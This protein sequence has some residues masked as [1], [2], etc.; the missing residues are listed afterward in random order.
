M[1][2]LIM[3]VTAGYGHN[4]TAKAM[5]DELVRRG[6]HVEILDVFAYLGK[7]AYNL[8]DKGYIITTKYTPKPYRRTYERLET[9]GK[10]RHAVVVGSE[11]LSLKFKSYFKY[12]NPDVVIC[13]HPF[14]AG[15]ANE[16]KQQSLLYAPTI[17]IVTDYTIHPFWDT[18][19]LIEYIMTPSELLTYTAERM[20]IDPSRLLPFGIPVNPKFNEHIEAADARKRLGLNPDKTTILVMG[21]SMG[22][23]NLLNYVSRMDS[24]R[25]N[26]QIVCI[27]GNNSKLLKKLTLL[28][29]NDPV[30]SY[31]FVNNVDEFMS[32]SDII[33]TKPGGITCT[34][35]MAKGLPMVLVDPIPGQEERNCDFLTNN[36]VAMRVNE[37]FSITEIINSIIHHPHRVQLM[38]ANIE[39][40][41]NNDATTKLADF[42]FRLR[43][44]LDII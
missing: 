4:S 30:A 2:V 26:F 19:E 37:S 35:A 13:T 5:K 14:A 34:E 42:V 3:T 38:K 43:Q 12:Y 7:L 10:L 9:D 24:M 29:T 33:V 22:H 41:S 39:L 25:N 20:S 28:K 15:I 17:G 8:I 1:K 32:A 36:G 40:I 31:G 27:C 21:G 23:G 11:P 44:G 18:A 6:V 16:L